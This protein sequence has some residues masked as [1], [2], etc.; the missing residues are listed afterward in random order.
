MIAIQILFGRPTNDD[1]FQ[2][3]IEDNP[4]ASIIYDVK[5]SRNLHKWIIDHGGCPIMW[6]T[7]HSFMKSKLKETG[8]SLAGEMSGHIFLMIIGLGLM[9]LSMQVQDYF[10]Y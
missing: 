3:C 2:R 8:A 1:F 4:G 9:M 7:G 5:C 10:Q 6:K